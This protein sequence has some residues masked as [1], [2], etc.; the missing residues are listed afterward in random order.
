MND[1]YVRRHS[2]LRGYTVH[3]GRLQSGYSIGKPKSAYFV[4]GPAW[5]SL[6][7]KA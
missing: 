5:D 6:A 2:D 4:R 3:L 1:S 7:E